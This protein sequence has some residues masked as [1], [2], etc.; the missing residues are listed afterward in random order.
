MKKK[1]I[2]AYLVCFGICNLFADSDDLLT[3]LDAYSRGDWTT[4]T[5]SFER[6]LTTA[7]PNNRTEALYWLVMSETSAQNYQRALNYAD[8]FLESASADERAAEVNYQKGRLLYLSGSYEAS[9][10]VLYRF[11]EKYP[12]HP[13]IPSAYYWIGEN[14]YAAGNHTEA[15]KIFS[16]VIVDY[17]QSGKVN[18]ARYK[19]V[20][21]DQQSVREELLQMANE[22]HSASAQA[23]KTRADAEPEPEPDKAAP[24]SDE[25]SA[26]VASDTTDSNTEDVLVADEA[27]ITVAA[28]TTD[29]TTDAGELDTTETAV[30]VPTDS[31]EAAPVTET[32]SLA[33]VEEGKQIE[34]FVSRLTALEKKINE[35]ST[36]LSLIAEEQENQRIREQQQAFEQQQK[37]EQQQKEAEQQELEKRRQELAGLKARAQ[38]LEKLYEQHM[39]G[40]K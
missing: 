37:V 4:A 8:T 18:E 24:K 13:K 23:E 9:L 36:A 5:A 15:R 21:I 40:A 6:V 20:L 33:T 10:D 7:D 19:I 27:A 3:G 17:P 16:K 25:S 1:L 38:T 12:D 29:T 26:S 22:A 31:A 11:I 32:S 2:L 28:D 30:A 14:L 34:H 35:I 39:K